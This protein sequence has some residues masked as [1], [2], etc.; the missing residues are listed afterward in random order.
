MRY[1]LPFL[2]FLCAQ[3]YHTAFLVLH[4]LLRLSVTLILYRSRTAHFV[5]ADDSRPVLSRLAS[6]LTFVAITH[7]LMPHLFDMF[8][9][10]EAISDLQGDLLALLLIMV[11][12][13]SNDSVGVLEGLLVTMTALCVEVRVDF[14]FTG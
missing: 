10:V 3:L 1:L 5:F 2:D 11:L 14:E 13:H 6:F 9:V 8:L 4:P 12:L 7:L